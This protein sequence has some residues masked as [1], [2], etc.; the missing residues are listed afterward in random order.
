MLLDPGVP[1]LARLRP[2]GGSA[3][4]AVQLVERGG[5]EALSEARSQDRLRIV[6]RPGGRQRTVR[7]GTKLVLSIVPLAGRQGETPH[8][9]ALQLRIAAV[10]GLVSI[11]RH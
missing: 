9:L 10:D 4:I 7:V 2:Q 3:V 6:E 11:D 8:D 1:G 5:L